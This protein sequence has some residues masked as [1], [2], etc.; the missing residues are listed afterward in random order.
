MRTPSVPVIVRVYVPGGVF[1]TVVRD[2]T[3][4]PPPGVTVT[5]LG[6]KEWLVLAGR[7]LT[8]R[9]TLPL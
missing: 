1:L 4:E 8:L 3:E 9:L 2:R 5:G 6:L 7:P